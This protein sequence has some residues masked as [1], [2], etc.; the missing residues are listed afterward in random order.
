[1]DPNSQNQRW[2]KWTITVTGGKHP[3]FAQVKVNAARFGRKVFGSPSQM[4]IHEF[5][6]GPRWEIEVLTEGHPAHEPLYVESVRQLWIRWG[7]EGFGLGAQVTVE[8]RLVAGSRQDGS[9]PDQMLI[10]PSLTEG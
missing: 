5:P 7:I 4:R 3:S 9:P 2:S 6:A 10:L 8:A 1:M